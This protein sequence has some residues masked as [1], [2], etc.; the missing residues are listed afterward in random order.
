M[1]IRTNSV[2]QCSGLP[3][4]ANLTMHIT[5]IWLED[6]A[7]VAWTRTQAYNCTCQRQ[8]ILTPALSSEHPGPTAETRPQMTLKHFSLE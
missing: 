6:R 5:Q 2:L 4:M 8:A 7:Q 3:Y 1:L